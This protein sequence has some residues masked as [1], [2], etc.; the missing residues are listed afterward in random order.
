MY[1]AGN[2]QQRK[3]VIFDLLS[4]NVHPIVIFFSCLMS[5]DFTCGNAG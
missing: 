5:D 3:P 4:G 1:V 2:P